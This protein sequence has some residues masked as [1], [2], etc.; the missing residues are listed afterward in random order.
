MYTL[1]LNYQMLISTLI[2]TLV[3]LSTCQLCFSLKNILILGGAGMMGSATTKLLMKQKTKFNLTLVNRGNWYWDSEETIKPFV[4]H[5]ECTRGDGFR[6]LCTRLND[7]LFYDAI[8]DF[9]CYHPL[10]MEDILIVFRGRFG[11]YIYI[12]SDSVYEVCQG[13]NHVGYSKETDALRP[14]DKA[15]Q[16][17]LNKRDSY[18]HRKL[19]GEETLQKFYQRLKFDYIA[20]RLPDVIGPRDNTNRFWKCFLWTKFTDIIGPVTIP[21]EVQDLPLS[22]VY[23]HDVAQLIYSLAD[24]VYSPDVYNQAYNLGFKKL[25]T[26]R[27]IFQDMSSFIGRGS[28][29]ITEGDFRIGFPSVTRGPVD[30]SKAEKML[31]WKP[32]PIEKALVETMEF[33]DDAQFNGDYK[34][35]MDRVLEFHGVSRDKYREFVIQHHK[36]MESR[37]KQEL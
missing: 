37:Q 16:E 12:S 7:G 21:K 19:Q 25:Y 23:S 32:T 31:A 14:H 20:L 3:I 29:N 5:Y 30:I 13:K 2:K 11:K 35:I 15:L 36:E 33:Y 9:S 28:V 18:G 4:H 26:L 27:N 34:Y 6:D 24:E 1:E 22:F 17:Q 10:D 8:V